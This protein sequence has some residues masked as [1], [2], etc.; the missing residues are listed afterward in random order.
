MKKGYNG[1]NEFDAFLTLKSHSGYSR[2]H[3]RASKYKLF[4]EDLLKSKG[5]IQQ[6]ADRLVG[7]RWFNR[8][9]LHRWFYKRKY[10][11]RIRKQIRWELKQYE[12]SY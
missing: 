2:N 10:S 4:H 3:H 7:E 9:Y 1:G 12:N 5:L 6:D 8:E 11:K